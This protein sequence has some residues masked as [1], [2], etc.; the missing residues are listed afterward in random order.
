MKSYPNKL[1][2]TKFDPEHKRLSKSARDRSASRASPQRSQG[3]NLWVDRLPGNFTES[4]VMELFAA[5]EPVT[6]FM[7]KPPV[8]SATCSAYVSF[9]RQE[10]AG[11]AIDALNGTILPSAYFPLRIEP[12]QR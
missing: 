7:K 6:V 1:V 5:H 12:Y 11:A 10:Q 3:T 4:Q 8:H 2:V 9:S